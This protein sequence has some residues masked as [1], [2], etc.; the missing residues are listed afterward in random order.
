MTEP[1]PA[2][3]LIGSHP[4]RDGATVDLALYADDED[5]RAYIDAKHETGKPPKSPGP[6][7]PDLRTNE[8][9]EREA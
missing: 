6:P 9:T 7:D 1:Q 8:T 3:L 5:Y 4:R 2:D